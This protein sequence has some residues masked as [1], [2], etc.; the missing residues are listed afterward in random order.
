MKSVRST[1]RLYDSQESKSH[2]VAK[3]HVWMSENAKIYQYRMR[4]RGKNHE[5]SIVSQTSIEDDP[6]RIV[7]MVMNRELGNRPIEP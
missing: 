4:W 2:R 5:G 1:I 6:V 7:T 3:I